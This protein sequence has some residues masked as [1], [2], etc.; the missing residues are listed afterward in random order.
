MAT[1]CRGRALVGALCYALAVP[2]P[3]FALVLYSPVFVSAI[4]KLTQ[5]GVYDYIALLLP[6]LESSRSQ[7]HPGT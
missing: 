5:L 7:P 6:R 2:L 1:P 3:A 4:F